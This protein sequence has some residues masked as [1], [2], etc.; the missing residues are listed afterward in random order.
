MDK[1]KQRIIGMINELITFLLNN[2]TSSI[3]INVKENDR[4]TKISIC[5]NINDAKV[6]KDLKNKIMSDRSEEVEELYWELLGDTNENDDLYILGSMIDKSNIK[7]TET[8]M[9]KII[10]IRKKEH[11]SN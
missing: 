10:L 6:L 7:Y 8:N 2:K 11:K 5:C 3:H 1:E 4:E 9:M